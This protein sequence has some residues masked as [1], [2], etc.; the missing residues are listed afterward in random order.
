MTLAFSGTAHPPAR[1]PVAGARTRSARARRRVPQHAAGAHHQRHLAQVLAAPT[2]PAQRD[3]HGELGEAGVVVAVAVVVRQV[4]RVSHP[5]L[6]GGPQPRLL[7]RVDQP[8]GHRRVD[9]AARVP[10]HPEVA[11]DGAAA[12]QHLDDL[13]VRSTASS[14][15]GVT[16]E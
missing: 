8:L 6:R 16:T 3:G 5:L 14:P 13:A 1:S 15:C 7:G 2:V 4:R 9:H 12:P 11:L 10:A